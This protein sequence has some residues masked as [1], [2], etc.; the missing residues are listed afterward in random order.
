[1]SS[2]EFARRRRKKS[3]RFYEY[4]ERR[5]VDMNE[6]RAIRLALGIGIANASRMEY[7]AETRM[8]GGKRL[9]S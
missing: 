3:A 6:A 2:S 1:M 9:G 7:V 4:A 8:Y 5:I